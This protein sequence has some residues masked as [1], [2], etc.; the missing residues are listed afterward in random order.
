VVEI[1]K[2]Q[3]LLKYICRQGFEH[4]VAANF[5]EVASAIHEAA[6]RYLG[7]ESHYHPELED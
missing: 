2:L 7:F 6:V 5:S 4:H 1:P 3:S